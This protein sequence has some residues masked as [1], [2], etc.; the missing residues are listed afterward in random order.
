MFVGAL[1]RGAKTGM[2]KLQLGL[3]FFAICL[4]RRRLLRIY[5]FFR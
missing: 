3:A 2:A 5:G 4:L 1:R